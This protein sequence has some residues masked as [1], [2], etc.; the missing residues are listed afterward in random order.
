M[1]ELY[2][3]DLGGVILPFDHKKIAKRLAKRTRDPSMSADRIFSILFSKEDGLVNAYEEGLLSSFDFFLLVKHTFKLEATF[4]EF[5]RA[6]NEIFKKDREVEEVL[7]RLKD[8]GKPLF[9]L[10]NTN[11]LHFSHLIASYPVLHLFDEW[12]L[13]FEVGA[14]KPKKE[15]FEKVFEK[16]DISPERVFYLDDIQ[17]NV[18]AAS[19]IGMRA[20]LFR[21]AKELKLLLR[22]EGIAL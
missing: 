6:W 20:Y 8:K 3:F 13:S 11:E 17:E 21:G 14:K 15:I 19:A 16:T 2:V 9:L 4:Q 12:I 22:R 1:V 5:K 18:D 10:S 7:V